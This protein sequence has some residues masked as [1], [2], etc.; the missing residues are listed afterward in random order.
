MPARSPTLPPAVADWQLSER[1]FHRPPVSTAVDNPYI[2]FSSRSNYKG[3]RQ[4]RDEMSVSE[5]AAAL[6]VTPT[7]VLRLIRLK[8]FCRRRRPVWAHPGY[9]AA[10]T[11]SDAWPTG[12]IQ[13]PHQWSIQRN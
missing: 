6:G 13:R 1:L 9:C 2:N 12:T 4:A 5:G 11:S 3:E 10:R 8:Q 7:T